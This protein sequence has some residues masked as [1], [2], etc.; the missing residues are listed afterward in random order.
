VV[1]VVVGDRLVITSVEGSGELKPIQDLADQLATALGRPV[2]VNL[3]TIPLQSS[4][5]FSP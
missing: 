5:S 2:V 4:S 3:L 1:R